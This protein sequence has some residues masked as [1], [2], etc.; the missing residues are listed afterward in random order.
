M[1]YRCKFFDCASAEDC[2]VRVLDVNHIEDNG[3]CPLRV[4]FPEGDV[5]CHFFE[6]FDP[7]A[8]EA[9]ERIL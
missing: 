3:F 4:S 9:N 8:A 1:N 7:L 6:G 5:K 2:I